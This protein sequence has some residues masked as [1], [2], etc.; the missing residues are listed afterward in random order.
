[1]HT[2]C[3]SY[4]FSASTISGLNISIVKSIHTE[5][6]ESGWEV[7]YARAGK[8]FHSALQLGTGSGRNSALRFGS[9]SAALRGVVGRM[10]TEDYALSSAFVRLAGGRGPN[11][12]VPMRA[13]VAPSSTAISKS[14]LI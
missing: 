13:I 8:L 14:P 11:S 9:G 4:S 6:K 3:F 10:S 1:M 7:Q 5:V 12:A 2:M